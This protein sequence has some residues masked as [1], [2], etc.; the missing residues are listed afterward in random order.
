MKEPI[1]NTLRNQQTIRKGVRV[2]IPANS[3]P[4]GIVEN[5]FPDMSIKASKLFMPEKALLDRMQTR[6]KLIK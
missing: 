5:N 6:I 4:K 2:A 1:I 3:S